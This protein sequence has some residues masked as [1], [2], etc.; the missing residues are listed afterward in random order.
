MTGVASVQHVHATMVWPPPCSISYVKPDAVRIVSIPPGKGDEAA[1]VGTPVTRRPPCSPGRAVFPH[2]VPRLHSHPRRGKPCLLWPAGRLAHAAPVRHVRD[3]WPFRAACFR[4]VL[5]RVVGFPHLRVLCSIRLPNR[6]RWAFPVTVL[7]HLPASCFT[8]TLRFQHCSVS[9]FPLPCL[10]SC[11]PYTV[12]FHGQERLGPPKFFDASLPACHGLRTP[13]DLP[14]LANPDGRVWP[15]GALKPSASAIAMSKLYQH[16]RGRGSPC[17]LQDTLSTLRPSCSPRV[18]PRLR[19]GRKTRYG[20]VARPYPTGTF[21]LQETPSFS[22]R[23]NAGPQAPPRAAATQE[24]RLL[25]SAPV[26]GS[27]W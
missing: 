24:R 23:E 26:R 14:L 6:I 1:T 18:Q 15:S 21:T 11:R 13:A 4:R 3:E 2:P 8:A 20:W 16:F 25:A 5:P 17:G 22:W 9:G 7:L 19:H 10:K 12:V 27:A